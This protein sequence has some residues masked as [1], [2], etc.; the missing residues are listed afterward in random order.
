M[1]FIFQVKLS[2]AVSRSNI[3]ALFRLCGRH[4]S[5][6][7]QNAETIDLLPAFRQPTVA[8]AVNGDALLRHLAAGCRDARDGPVMGG[9]EMP[10]DNG[11][12]SIADDLVEDETCSG[13]CIQYFVHVIQPSLK[14]DGFAIDRVVFCQQGAGIFKPARI[15]AIFVE[16]T[17]EFAGHGNLQF[18][19]MLSYIEYDN[20]L[21]IGFCTVISE[22]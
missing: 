9:V 18:D 6:L 2:I 20:I 5:D 4:C 1:P 3:I 19:N 11:V 21:S 16:A 17:N 12:V 10:A 7:F 14:A 22:A 8:L 13:E 15:D